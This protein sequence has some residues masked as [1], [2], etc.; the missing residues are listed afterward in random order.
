MKLFFVDLT[1]YCTWFDV[2]N[3]ITKKEVIKIKKEI[4]YRDVIK[5][6]ERPEM[7][8]KKVQTD[9]VLLPEVKENVQEQ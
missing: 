7:L 8:N 3:P 6:P 5:E 4:V 2:F 9:P 1:Y